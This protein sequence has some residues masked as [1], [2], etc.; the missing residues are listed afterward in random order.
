MNITAPRKLIQLP[1]LTWYLLRALSMQP[2]SLDP[3]LEKAERHSSLD[4][5]QIPDPQFIPTGSDDGAGC[6]S[7]SAEV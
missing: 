4:P 6:L 2:E 5:P 1:V 3:S 7:L